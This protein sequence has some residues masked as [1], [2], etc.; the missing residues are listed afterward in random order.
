MVTWWRRTAAAPLHLLPT[1]WFRNTWSWPDGGSKPR[2]QSVRGAAHRVIHTHHPDPL[3]QESLD[4]YDL[5][6]QGGGPLLFSENETNRAGGH[7]PGA[8][9]LFRKVMLT[10]ASIPV[11]FPPYTSPSRP[12][13]Q[14]YEEMHVNGGT[15]A[16]VFFYGFTLDLDAAQ[17]DGTQFNLAYIPD[18]HDIGG[19]GVL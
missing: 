1:L 3:F 17:R 18:D 14:R 9:E 12:A 15:A 11:A 5:Y 10:S 19:P 6:C 7:H 8:V 4:D 2:L 13:D 16:Q